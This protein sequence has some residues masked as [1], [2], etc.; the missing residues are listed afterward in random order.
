MDM[1]YGL[2]E[3]QYML[4]YCHLSQNKQDVT[5][6]R[7]EIPQN[8]VQLIQNAEALITNFILLSFVLS[9]IMNI[10]FC[11][12]NFFSNLKKDLKRENSLVAQYICMDFSLYR[13]TSYSINKRAE[14]VFR[15]PNMINVPRKNIGNYSRFLDHQCG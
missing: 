7:L 13:Y 1:D 8:S 12:S 14:I 15:L 3:R 2:F 11:K 9:S 4:A 10:T 6:K 5:A